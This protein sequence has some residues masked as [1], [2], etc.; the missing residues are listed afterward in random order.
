MRKVL[1]SLLIGLAGLL[2]ACGN[3]GQRASEGPAPLNPALATPPER[4][5]VVGYRDE[6]NLEAVSRLLGARV[7]ATLPELKAALLELPSGLSQAEAARRVLG[8]ARYAEPNRFDRSPIPL[9]NPRA[10]TQGITPQAAFNDPLLPQ[11]WWIPK[12][13]APAA[14]DQGGVGRGVTIGIVDTDFDRSHPDLCD[15]PARTRCLPGFNAFTL[16]AFAPTAPFQGQQN[17]DTH[18]S[19]SAGMAAALSNNGQ[20]VA[21]VAGGNGNPSTAARLRPLVIFGG[22]NGGYVGDFGVAQ[23][24]VWAVDHGVDVLNNSWGGGGYSYLLKEAFDYALLHGV[25]V[26]ASAGNDY[27]DAYH[28]PSG[29]PGLIAVAATNP[30]DEKT[31]FSTYGPWVDLSA[32]G[33]DV[34]TTFVN[35]GTGTWLFGGTSAAGPV[36]AGSAAVVLQVLRDNGLNPTPYQVL[37]ILQQTADPVQGPSDVVAGMGAGRVNVG[38]AVQMARGLQSPSQLPPPGSQIGILVLNKGSDA[39]LGL[40]SLVTTD[41]LPFV[42]FSNVTLV[43]QS[44]K[45]MYAQTSPAGPALFL[46]SP[47]GQYQVL[48]GGPSQIFLG[49]SED[50]VQGAVSVLPGGEALA[51]LRQQADPYEVTPGN[52]PARNDTPQTATDLGQLFGPLP[53]AFTLSAAFDSNNLAQFGLPQG[54]PDVDVYALSLSAGQTL[55]LRAASRL[56]GGLG[57]VKLTLLAP[58]GTTVLQ[59]AQ[60]SPTSPA[61]ISYQASQAGTYYLKLEEANGQ[62]GLGYFYRLGVGLGAS[63]PAF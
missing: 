51:V 56:V 45:Q 1:T 10:A 31:G 8:L 42:P 26:V 5:L 28:L 33:E 44:G 23:A 12:I 13:G 55:A 35:L 40:G 32:P 29:L 57:T 18:G 9:P 62:Q 43:H 4:Q 48:V 39:R 2:A 60:E 58:D 25:I 47:P 22:Q 38:R 6:G 37:R 52:P 15:Q 49:G 30:Y 27:R 36:V 20:Y 24:L 59:S 7:I 54:G 34:L 61:Q 14:W 17:R 16:Q 3:L 46:E 19:G 11:Q 63:P 21:G 50:P 41:L 53:P